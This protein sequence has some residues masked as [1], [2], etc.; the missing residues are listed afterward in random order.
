MMISWELDAELPV[1]LPPDRIYEL[2]VSVL[3]RKV[4]IGIPGIGVL[5]FC[6]FEPET[7]PFEREFCS[8]REMLNDH[9]PLS[10]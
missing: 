2:L 1:K 5:G 8:C 3:D 4:T 7:C 9:Q 10:K 6:N